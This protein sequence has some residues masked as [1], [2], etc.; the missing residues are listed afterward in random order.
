MLQG[1]NYGPVMAEVLTPY[2]TFPGINQADV[3]LHLPEARS[4]FP[5]WP[6]LAWGGLKS[7]L[8]SVELV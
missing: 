7:R 4:W 2:L 3:F 6:L 8:S 1:G 5:I